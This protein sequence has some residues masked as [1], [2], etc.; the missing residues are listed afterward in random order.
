[1][2]VEAPMLNIVCLFWPF[3]LAVSISFS[4]GKFICQSLR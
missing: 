2:D 3:L 1:M 4:M